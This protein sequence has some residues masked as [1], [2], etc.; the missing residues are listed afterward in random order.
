MTLDLT[1]TQLTDPGDGRPLLVVGPS[2]GTSVTGLWSSCAAR[3]AGRFHVVGWDL[4]RKKAIYVDRV[5]PTPLLMVVA[6]G[7]ML[8]TRLKL[9]ETADR[10]GFYGF[11][12]AEHHSTPLGMSPSLSWPTTLRTAPCRPSRLSAKLRSSRVLLMILTV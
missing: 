2:I 7:D 11:H 8:E 6:L 9:V 5:S 10:E 3:L 4:P 12:M 1:A